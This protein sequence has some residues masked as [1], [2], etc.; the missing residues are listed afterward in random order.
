MPFIKS[1]QNNSEEVKIYYEDLGKGK[2]IV[3][4][5]GWPL[6]GAMWEY[7]ITQLPQQGYRCITY[8]RRGFG[9][10]DKPATGYDYNSL[11]GDLKSL[12]EG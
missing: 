3:F 10:S 8:D 9:N 2:T 12:I 11:A 7:Q 4:I 6:N 5:H 1:A